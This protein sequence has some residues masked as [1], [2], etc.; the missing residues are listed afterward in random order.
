MVL[1]LECEGLY[2]IHLALHKVKLLAIFGPATLITQQIQHRGKAKYM[3]ALSG[4]RTRDVIVK[5]DFRPDALQT[6]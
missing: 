2:W 4:T 6:V 5:I 3:L 1:F